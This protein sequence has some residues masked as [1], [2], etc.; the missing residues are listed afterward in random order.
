MSFNAFLGKPVVDP[1]MYFLLLEKPP[2]NDIRHIL[3]GENLASRCSRSENG[4][5]LTLSFSYLTK[6][7]RIQAKL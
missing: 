1:E 4:T 6:K 3:C 7:A 2:Y 5:H